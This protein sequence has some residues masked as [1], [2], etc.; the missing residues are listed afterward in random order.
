[1][2]S[3][4]YSKTD[5]LVVDGYP[6]YPGLYLY[7][8][9]QA[10]SMASQKF[11]EEYTG[12]ELFEQTIDDIP[13]KD[14]IYTKTVDL[15]K[16]FVFIEKSFDRLELD[17]LNV[18][19]EMAY[20]DTTLREEWSTMSYFYTRNGI[21]Y[22]TFRKAY[23]NYLKSNLLFTALYITEGG[24]EEVPEEEILEVFSNNYTYLDYIRVY[25]VDE[26]GAPLTDTK[27]DSIHKD[28][29]AMKKIAEDAVKE[30]GVLFI[31]PS[32]IGIQAAFEYY[33]E[34]N[35]LS[36]EEIE[37]EMGKMITEHS[38]LKTTST[39]YEEEYL[40]MIFEAKYD[41][42]FIYEAEDSF[43]LFCRRSM[44]EF[45]DESWLDYRSVIISE[46]R[47]DIYLEYLTNNSIMLSVTEKSSARR[48]FNMKKANI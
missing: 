30:E 22:E 25:K 35:Q 9:L 37:H 14:W 47:T 8:Q 17:Y 45:N 43:Y 13:T 46:L 15:A 26:D 24:E 18:E 7:F 19:L 10:I 29:E 20:Y 5:V 31:Y 48:Y 21:G 38:I 6:I 41:K 1:M 3:G 23:E 36:E 28:V 44:L 16:E 4:C 40:T 12:K 32:N 33:A 27:I 34:I 2:L 11:E 39:I 42:F